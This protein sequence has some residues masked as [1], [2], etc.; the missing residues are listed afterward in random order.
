MPHSRSAKKRV[1][2]NLKRRLRNRSVKSAAKTQIKKFLAAVQAGDVEAARTQFRAAARVLDK[3]AT[4][5]VLHK[6]NAA[7]HKSRLA[8]K[9][10]RLSATPAPAVP[11]SAPET[12][13]A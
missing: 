10:N 13:Q 11:T 6:R 9:L 1:R 7:R 8:A 2:Q 5:G 4:R 12:P 3:A